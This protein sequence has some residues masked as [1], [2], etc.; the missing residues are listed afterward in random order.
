ML[1]ERKKTIDG[2]LFKKMILGGVANLRA[3]LQEVNDLNV[4]PIPDGD[5]GE[6]MYL[7]LQGG[8][9]QLQNCAGETLAETSQ[10]MSQGMLLGARG[11]SGV[12]LSQLFYGLAEGLSGLETADLRQFGS[13]L[14]QGVKCAYGAVAH[15]VEGTIL[16]VAREAVENACAKLETET[17]VQD[18]FVGYLYEMKKSLEKTPDLLA[19]L[20]EAGVIDSGGAGLVYITE[21]FCKTLGG[22]ELENELSV[23]ESSGKK[24]VDLSKFNENSEMVYGYC[25]E[26]LL[27]LQ[28]SKTDVNNFD[29]DGFK[30]FL[31]SVGDSVVAFQ[32][33]TIIKIH[34]HTLTPWVV[35]KECQ[36]YGEFLTV[37]IE[38]MTL[39]HNE[40]VKEE[41]PTYQK[42]ELK[43]PKR[44]RRKFALVTV[45]TGEG[46]RQTFLDMGA[47]YVICGGQTNNPSSED[48]VQAFDEVN[49]DHIFV[50]PNNGN[51]ILAANQAAK[52]YA[53]S[54]IRVI[55]SKNIGQGYSALSMLDYGADDADEIVALLMESM[56]STQTGMVARSVRD[57]VL[58]GVTVNK[59]EYMGFT[60][61]TMLVCMPKKVDALCALAEKM[62]VGE[63]EYFLVSYGKGVTETEKESFRAY[64]SESYPALELYEIDGGQDVYDF[65]LIVE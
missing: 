58:N 41:K 39:Q 26:F 37:K 12:I 62:Q 3:N 42:T 56:Q 30:T 48:F 35:M 60:D 4:F 10:A 24:A 59:D 49:A 5:T 36:N 31:E 57:T 11:N 38:N 29:L 61:K 34:V 28:T 14:K 15:P 7:T 18:F 6:N 33:G 2:E 55:E 13:A 43:K 25:T 8:L 40:T 45:A 65:L 21:G 1:N 32:T 19:V 53:D 17:T 50:L 51:V 47:D 44:A 46:L 16:T 54:D 63:R 22:E 23:A 9:D 20:K 64:V 27:Q 52:I